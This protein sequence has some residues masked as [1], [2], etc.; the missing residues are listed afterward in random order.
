MLEAVARWVN[1]AELLVAGLC[2]CAAASALG[3]DVFARHVFNDGIYGVQKFAVY[4]SAIAGALGISIV[5]QNGGH[6]RITVIDSLIPHD[7]MHTVSRFGDLVSACVFLFLAWF[8]FAFVY[9]TYAFGET[10]TILGIKI[11]QVQIVLPIAFT[12]SGMKFLIQV[13]DPSIIKQETNL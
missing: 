8:A 13:I 2:L 7:L 3:A 1:R 10:D 5:I 11:W 6:L 12:L 9:D 4:C